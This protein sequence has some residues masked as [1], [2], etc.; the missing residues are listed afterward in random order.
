MKCVQERRKNNPGISV[1]HVGEWVFRFS[2]SP[3]NGCSFHMNY[4]VSSSVKK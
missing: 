4:M 2:S 1:K 3:E